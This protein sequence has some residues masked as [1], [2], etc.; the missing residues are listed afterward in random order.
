MK[1]LKIA[2]KD[3]KSTTKE[4]TF[5]TVIVL[6]LF[7][8]LFASVLTFGLLVLYN[9]SFAGL[10]VDTEVKVGF[11]GNAPIL[12][13]IIEPSK[14]YNSIGNA[15]DDFYAGKIDAI[16]W[17]PN[18]NVSGTNFVR[19]YLPK[20][21]IKA[22]QTSIVIKE[23]LI[24]YQKVMRD[25]RGIPSSI[26]IKTYS[27]DLKEIDVPKDV[28]IPFKFIYVV[29]IPLLMITTA[30]TAAGIFIDMVSEEIETKTIH[31]LLA[32]PL[33]P[34]DIVG[35]KILAAFLLAAILT[36]TWIFLLMLNRVDMH[37]PHFVIIMALSMVLL[38]IS[39]ASITVAIAKDRERS[40]L[41]YSLAIIALIPL[42]FISPYTPAGL[43]ARI[44]ANS[45]FNPLHVLFYLITSILL[46]IPSQKVLK[47]V[48]EKI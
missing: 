11:V 38:F 39:F 48:F 14:K 41:L 18:E 25:L 45:P 6:Q 29:L 46:L 2:L 35:G 26:E 37:N 31:V 5:I 34:E 40:Q 15:L 16:V 32:T 9:P 20:E 8:A 13:A 4:R 12:E 42:Q 19:L 44:A 7:V 21:E 1:A 28:S 22:I 3:L 10:T 23:K 17:L 33:K 47:I 27:T 36:P 24:K 43:V 30:A